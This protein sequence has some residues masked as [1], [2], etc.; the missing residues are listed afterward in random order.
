MFDGKNQATRVLKRWK[1]P[2][3]ITDVPKAGFA[4]KNSSYFVEDGSYLR[5]KNLT[6]SYNFTGKLLKRWGV[7]RLQPYFTANNLLTITGY[8]GM[9]P[10]VNEW[11][12]DGGVQGI[13]WGSYPHS[14]SFVFGVNIEF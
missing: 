11:G 1:E 5:L 12:N 8:K 3:Q 4:I 13:D 2:G 10:E 14:K 9:D 7:T 6:F